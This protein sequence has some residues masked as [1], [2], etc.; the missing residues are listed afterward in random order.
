MHFALHCIA[1]NHS[2]IRSLVRCIVLIRIAFDLV[3]AGPAAGAGARPA[4]HLSGQ[5]QGLKDIIDR[6]A[7]LPHAF[8][9]SVVTR[10]DRTWRGR[11]D[12][13]DSAEGDA[14]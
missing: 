2:L 4:R 13:H 7:M 9:G 14:R 1:F 12:S 3:G 6:W 10:S 5:Q 8:Q 11:R